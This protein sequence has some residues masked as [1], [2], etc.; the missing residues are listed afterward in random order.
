[1]QLFLLSALTM[2]AFAANS[3]LNRLAVDSGAIDAASFAALRV[4]SG[5]VMLGILVAMRGASLQLVARRRA[6][7][8]LAL[9]AYMVGFSSAYV[10]LDAGLGALVLFGVVQITMFLLAALRGAPPTGAQILGASIAFAG[11]AWVLWPAGGAAVAPS[12]VAFMIVA[13]IGWAIYTLAGRTEPDALAGTAANFIVALP[14]VALAVPL[15]G[16]PLTMSPAGTGL[17]MLSGAVT[18]GLGYALWYSILPRFTPSTA[19][20]LQLAVP[21]IAL[22]AGVILLG[23]AA[24]LRLALGAALVLGGIALAVL[25]GRRRAPAK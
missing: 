16:A 21:V 10:T 12:G 14:L 7:G 17:A 24:S 19:A 1:M 5:A 8:A 20:I 18:S 22:V 3:I 9:V 6:V 11:L 13:G 15:T 4:L 23:E 25:S 2:T